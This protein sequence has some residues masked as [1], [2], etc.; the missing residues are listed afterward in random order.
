MR[1]YIDLDALHRNARFIL[2][3]AGKPVAAVVKGDAYGHDVSLV[4]PSLIVAGVRRFVVSSIRE[5]ISLW[6]LG[7]EWILVLHPSPDDMGIYDTLPVDIRNSFR[8]AVWDSGIL[9]FMPPGSRVH[10][11]LNTGFG[12]GMNIDEVDTSIFK[13]VEVEGIMG[14]VPF[15]DD[16]PQHQDLRK[17]IYGSFMSAVSHLRNKLPDVSEIHICNSASLFY[18]ERCPDTTM[19]R[20]GVALY[21]YVE[22]VDIRPLLSPVMYQMAD[23]IAI[24]H[25]KKGESV[26]YGNIADRNMTIAFVRAGYGD[27]Y[28]GG[29]YALHLESGIYVK[30]VFDLTMNVSAFDVSDVSVKVGDTL[31]LLGHFEKIRADVI[32]EAISLSTEKVLTKAGLTRRQALPDYI[33][34]LLQS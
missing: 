4:V 6:N 2:K 30:R 24:S 7:A 8:F 29:P 14:H 20:V 21:G 23:I 9:Q 13:N 28:V 1:V 33:K 3:K 19:F 10:I 27:G 11:A 31:V 18:L 17:E 26:F 34:D 25:V 16:T 5:A 15:L 22:K 12:L 32:A